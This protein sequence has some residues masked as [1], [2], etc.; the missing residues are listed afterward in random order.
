MVD[1]LFCR[2]A[3]VILNDSRR[4]GAAEGWMRRQ[5]LEG[6]REGECAARARC[7]NVYLM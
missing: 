7:V 1:F 3:L 4:G 2:D 6:G 5:R